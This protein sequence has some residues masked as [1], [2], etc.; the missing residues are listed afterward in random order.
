M[1]LDE[2]E[3]GV[4]YQA[5]SVEDVLRI[6]T[7]HEKLVQKCVVKSYDDEEGAFIIGSRS[8]VTADTYSTVSPNYHSEH[9]GKLVSQDQLDEFISLVNP[10]A[11]VLD[12]GTGPG[13]DLKYL[14]ERYGTTGIEVSKRFAEIAQF[15]NPNSEIIA[16][17]IISYDLG[18]KKYKGIWAR[19]SIHHIPEDKLDSVFKKI[20]DSLVE[21]GIFYVIVR[22]GEG[23]FMEEEKKSYSKNK[24]RRFYH[25][26]TED[27]L[28]QRAKKQG[29]ELV[30]LDHVQRSH[31]WIVG[32]FKK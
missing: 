17:D 19:D 2:T 16:G 5:N 25:L 15:E 31:K 24:L 32:I 9:A 4:L 1:Y 29:F 14:S 10:P 21:E 30:K 23:E 26:F 28:V 3:L 6:L 11:Q 13:Y 22:E 18:Q 8:K 7:D 27:E 20:Y 12:I